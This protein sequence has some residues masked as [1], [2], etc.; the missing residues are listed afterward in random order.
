VGKDLNLGNK[1]ETKSNKKIVTVL[2]AMVFFMSGFS[3][4][5]VPLYDVFCDITGLNGKTA[6]GPAVISSNEVDLDRTVK[7]QF[8]ASLNN[9][10]P[11][12]FRPDV[13]EVKVHP[14]ELNETFFFA[15]NLTSQ[16]KVAQAVPS[17]APGQAALYFHKTECFCFSEQGFKPNEGRDMP[18]RFMVDPELPE[19]I[20]TLTLSY[21]F[22]ELDKVAVK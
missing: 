11:W 20:E 3:F 8:I 1:T 7:V 22:F 19:N 5:L 10:A 2:V 6:D 12:E 13:F 21:T 17:V 4:A 15:K 16:S 18:L 14:G 9:E